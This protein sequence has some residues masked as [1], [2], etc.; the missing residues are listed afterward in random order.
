MIN[1]HL[2]RIVR[3]SL[4]MAHI[5]KGFVRRSTIILILLLAACAPP[6]S[7]PT[8]PTPIPTLIPATE[9]ASPLG[10]ATAPAFTIQ[11]YPARLPSAM[12]GQA[13]YQTH[14][15]D[16]HGVDGNGVVPG[17]RNFGDLDYMRGETPASFY[18]AVTEGRGDMPSFRDRLTSDERW[19]VVFYV[20]RFSTNAETL[21]L[22]LQIYE[23]NCAAC[24]GQDGIGTVLGA[25]DFTDL[26]LV[27]SRAPRDFYLTVTQGKGSM[28]AWQ[29]RLSQGERWAVIDYLRTFSYDPILAEEVAL[30]QPTASAGEVACDPVYLS[31]NNPFAWDDA[32]VVAAGQVTYDQACTMC[33]GADGAGALPGTPD[34]T[35][36]DTQSALRAKSGEFLCVVAEGSN[37]M[38]GWKETLS[39]EQ[40]WQVLT[41]I[42]SLEQ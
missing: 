31:Q 4:S 39:I 33:H 10:A 32:E 28:P 3:R 1:H 25:A 30:T 13:I 21:A 5:F 19:D 37:A 36:T 29:G 27:D 42:A 6:R 41:F 24:H 34:L 2:W 26:R 15:A 11:S 40:M 22:G 12:L 7:L 16:C 9:P 38:P 18:A 23:S 20:W 14:C 35:T 17:A 8:G